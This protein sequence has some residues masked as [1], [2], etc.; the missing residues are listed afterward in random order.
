MLV[1]LRTMLTCPCYK[2]R[3]ALLFASER[4]GV[5]EKEEDEEDEEEEKIEDD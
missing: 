4:Y 2:L 3:T 1:P 5:R